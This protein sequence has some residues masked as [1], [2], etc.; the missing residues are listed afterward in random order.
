[1]EGVFENSLDIFNN[2]ETMVMPSPVMYND[3]LHPA[4][5]HDFA[6]RSSFDNIGLSYGLYGNAIASTQD[7]GATEQGHFAL[8]PDG[9]LF[10]PF[11]H[12][13]QYDM[14]VIGNQFQ[15]DSAD[16]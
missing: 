7:A 14:D 12:P 9:P 10:S 1:M 4:A 16:I 11:Q 15:E 6:G 8:Q 3:T 2:S 13:S 5:F